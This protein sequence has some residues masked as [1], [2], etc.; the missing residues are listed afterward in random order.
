MAPTKLW[1][2]G[3]LFLVFQAT[4]HLHV[5]FCPF[6]NKG[7]Y[8][9]E[10]ETSHR[11]K[12]AHENVSCF[13][14]EGLEMNLEHCPVMTVSQAQNGEEKGLHLMPDIAGRPV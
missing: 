14:V 1:P 7:D 11:G 2:V 4:S 5:P 13:T 8:N 9:L 12:N 10:K 6:L 3:T